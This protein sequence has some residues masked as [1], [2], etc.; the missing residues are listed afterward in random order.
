MSEKESTAGIEIR[1]GSDPEFERFM[2]ERAAI[3]YGK[4][5]S[6]GFVPAYRCSACLV[7]A[8]DPHLVGCPNDPR[9]RD[10]Q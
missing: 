2:A 1:L 6:L 3:Y 8:P 7:G 4:P 9:L 5:N 10:S